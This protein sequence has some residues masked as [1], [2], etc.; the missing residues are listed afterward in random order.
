[1]DTAISLAPVIAGCMKWGQWGARFST[2]A[3][4]ALIEQCLEM[5]VTSFDHAD[6]YGH[7][8]TEEEFG[9][10]LIQKPSIRS[11]MQ[12]ITK[13]GINIV[14]PNRPGHQIKSYDT[15]SVHI[16]ESVNR[17]LQNLQTEYIDILL[18]H[19][20]DPLMN[21]DEIGEAFAK[22]K[23]Q[24]K[25]LHFGVSN[26]TPYQVDLLRSRIAV[27]VNQIEI[28]LI[29]T[30]PFFDGSLNQ[31]MIHN[32]IPMSWSPLGG[33]KVI[34]NIEDERSRKILAVAE[35]LGMKYDITPDQVLL[36]WLWKHPA[37][38]IPVLGTTKPERIKASLDAKSISLTSEEWFLLLRASLGHEV[39]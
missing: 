32:I 20:P 19:R 13:C 35:I 18:I 24:G 2:A 33:G 22:L 4:D 30:D 1:M 21:P 8:T 26:F 7:Y 23:Q 31:C 3:Y 5:G 15:G 16:I 38:I 6:I 27:S 9:K 14:S 25:V 36:A 29:S 17:S 10:V 12:L 11:R 37:N 28:S 39:A 34:N